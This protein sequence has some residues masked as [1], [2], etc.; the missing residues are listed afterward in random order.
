[1]GVVWDMLVSRRDSPIHS[2]GD[3]YSLE[4]GIRQDLKRDSP[5]PIEL[6]SVQY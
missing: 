4:N 3:V 6:S 2:Q 5:N 1:M